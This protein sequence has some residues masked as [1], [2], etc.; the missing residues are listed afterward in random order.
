LNR[1]F[2]L[3]LRVPQLV[4]WVPLF[5]LASDLNVVSNPAALGL[6]CAALVTPLSTVL[7]CTYFAS[8]PLDL[9]EAAE[10]DASETYALKRIDI[11]MSKGTI[12][13]VALLQAIT[14]WNE[15]ALAVI[16]LLEPDSLAIPVGPSSFGA[17]SR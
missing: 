8:F 14:P 16:L 3:L 10:V 17:S 9:I 7:M 12:G 13:R 2:V 4:I 6:V 11:P 5:S 15:L 1:Y